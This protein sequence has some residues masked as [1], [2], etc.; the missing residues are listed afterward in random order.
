M[1][2]VWF[3]APAWYW[4]GPSTL[5]PIGFG[6]DEWGRRVLVLGWTITGRVLIAVSRPGY[7][8]PPNLDFL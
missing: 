8:Y 6:G 3:W 2:K 7:L 5:L 1:P 4:H